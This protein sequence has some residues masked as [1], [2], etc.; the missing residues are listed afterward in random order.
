MRL[1]KPSWVLFLRTST[2]CNAG[3]VTCPAGRKTETDK[4]PGGTMRPEMLERIVSYIKKQANL[5]SIAYHYYNEPTMNPW[6]ADLVRVGQSHKIPG[7]MST[8]C[9]F[10]KPMPDILALGLR[11]LIISVSGFTQSVHE[12]SHKGVDIE[13]V[14]QNMRLIA[15][16]KRPCTYVRVSWHRY[17]YNTHEE[18]LMRDFSAKLGFHFTPYDTGVLPLER[19]FQRWKDGLPDVAERDVKTPLRVARDLCLQRKHWSCIHQDRMITV[20]S[21]GMIHACCVKNHAANMSGSLFETD[22]EEFNNF[23]RR[24]DSRCIAC[25]ATGLHVYA[26]QQYRR[27]LNWRVTA[28]KSL[29]N[30]WRRN[31][32]G[33]LFP[34][35][36]ALWT[37]IVYNR[38]HAE[39]K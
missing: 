4:Q 34:W 15:A 35:V 23:R 12:R 25:K 16:F 27:P 32:L 21:D 22:L 10:F 26:M 30:F 14:K 1:V 7:V 2:S 13:T 11:N 3:C 36:S 24:Y 18:H 39:V 33:G 6:I 17:A 38:P 20:D 5:T 9:S 31:S 37:D 28:M 29:E 19:V 8:N